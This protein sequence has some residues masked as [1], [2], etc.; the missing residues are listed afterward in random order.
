MIW[1]KPPQSGNPV[2]VTADYHYTA[3]G[4][5][6]GYSSVGKDTHAIEKALRQIKIHEQFETAASGKQ[7]QVLD[8]FE[9]FEQYLTVASS[10]RRHSG[11]QILKAV[12]F[13]GVEYRN[14]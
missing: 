4:Q 3:I 8:G 12:V 10:E 7:K 5:A 14:L 1:R 2:I 9:S 11:K 13:A 6:S